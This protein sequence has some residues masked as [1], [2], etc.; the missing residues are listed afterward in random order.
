MEIACRFD[1]EHGYT[2]WKIGRSVANNGR[3]KGEWGVL[4][5]SEAGMGYQ[6]GRNKN[7]DKNRR[8]G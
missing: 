3:T 6:V 8:V 4:V 1:V 7:L 5:F 2:E